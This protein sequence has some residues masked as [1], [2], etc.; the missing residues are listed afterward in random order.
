MQAQLEYSATLY[1]WDEKKFLEEKGKMESRLSKESEIFMSFF[2]PERK[3]D[4]LSKK[5]TMWKI[6]LDVDGKRYEGKATKI[7]LQLAEIE[8]LYP[9]HNRF[10]TPYTVVFPIAM[11]SIERRPLEV[12]VTGVVG[13]GTLKFALPASN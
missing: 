3:N 6:F 5:N 8:A 1:Q 10:Y 7:K 11:K 13:S 4:D 9:Y 2:T 12:T